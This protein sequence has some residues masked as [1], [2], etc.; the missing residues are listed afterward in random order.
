MSILVATT[1]APYKAM[2][3]ADES[4]AWLTF[5]LGAALPDEQVAYFAAIELDPRGMEPY[6]PFIARLVDQL[7]GA[8]WTFS[9]Q[10]DATEVGTW[11]RLIR[12]CTGRNMCQEYA[13]LHGYEW[14]LFLDTDVTPEPECLPKLLE[15]NWPIVG[16]NVVKYG[17]HG[18]VLTDYPF[19]V[20]EHWNTAGM[21]LLHHSVYARIPWGTDPLVGMTD[22]PTYQALCD[23]RLNIKTR[24]RHDCYGQHPN[25]IPVEHRKNIDHTRY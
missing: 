9:M 7:G 20:E 25:L 3:G 16:G 19:P 23:A 21:L 12:I 5:D 10:T 4:L 17:L 15:L 22:D 11:D 18:R 24:V 13:H 1:I 8:Y 14:L 6:G 2:A